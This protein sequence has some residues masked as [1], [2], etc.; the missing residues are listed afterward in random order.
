M[1]N[2]EWAMLFNREWS[3]LCN[4]ENEECNTEQRMSDVF[5]NTEWVKYHAE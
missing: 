5:Q 4:T 2:R 3:I 1:Q